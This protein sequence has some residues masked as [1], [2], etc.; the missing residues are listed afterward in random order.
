MIWYANDPN[1]H[2]CI[3]RKRWGLI[4]GCLKRLNYIGPFTIPSNIYDGAFLR[5]YQSAALL[6][7]LLAMVI[8]C[9]SLENKE[10]HLVLGKYKISQ[11]SRI[12]QLFF[13]AK[14]LV[15]HIEPYMKMI[16][17]HCKNLK[18]RLPRTIKFFWDFSWDNVSHRS[19]KIYS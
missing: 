12:N 17:S 2:I 19:T 7:D 13:W 11:L 5:N 15:W 9:Y 16:K 18:K 1:V 4:L 14:L 3:F 6:A 8:R 10:K